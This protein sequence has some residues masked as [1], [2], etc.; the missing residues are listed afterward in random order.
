MEKEL[1][2]TI[3]GSLEKLNVGCTILALLS[4]KKLDSSHVVVEYNR[5]IIPKHDFGTT[6]VKN[7]DSVEIL[8]FVGG[9]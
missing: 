2:A 8:H 1:S 3:N 4:E 7:G 6:V 9:G 5:V